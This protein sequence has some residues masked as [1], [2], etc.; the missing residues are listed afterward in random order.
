MF[1]HQHAIGRGQRNRAPRP[2][3]AN[4]RRDH[5]HAEREALLGRAGDRFGLSALLGLDPGKC[6]RRV[7]QCHH[8]YVEAV[9]ELH[10]PDRLAVAFGLGHPE[11][12]LEPRGGVVAFLMPDQHHP[13]PVDLGQPADD[14]MVVGKRAVARQ[15]EEIVRDPGDIIVE[16]RALG[17]PRDL[18]LL[19]RSQLGIGIAQQLA[20]L[21]CKLVDLGVDIDGARLGGLAQRRDPLV[22]VGDRFF[23]I[24]IG[25]H[26]PRELG[27]GGAHVN[28]QR[29]DAGH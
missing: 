11:I 24:E 14:G 16:M 9:G 23:K 3:F 6:A 19:P 12:M 25:L 7:D 22:E 27:C 1:E 21:G 13:A 20:R 18:S 17:V 29:G 2:A 28:D 10:Q 26:W 15:L 4:H 8:R 5:R